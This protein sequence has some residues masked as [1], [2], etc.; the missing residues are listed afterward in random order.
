MDH[1]YSTNATEEGLRLDFV[2][3]TDADA[4]GLRQDFR[5]KTDADEEGQRKDFK[6]SAEQDRR[7]SEHKYDTDQQYL[8]DKYKVDTGAETQLEIMKLYLASGNF[9]SNLS[10]TSPLFKAAAVQLGEHISRASGKLTQAPTPQEHTPW[11]HL[12]K[13]KTSPAG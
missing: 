9:P 2:Y 12:F 8:L 4:K 10:A 7:L 3:K 6:C 13:K 11:A 1:R 5:Y